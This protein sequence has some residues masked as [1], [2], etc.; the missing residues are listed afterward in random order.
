MLSDAMVIKSGDW[1]ARILPEI[2]ANPVK[3]TY[4]GEDVLRPLA[5]MDA[6]KI[7]PFLWGSP[8]LIPANRTDG[9][10]FT[11]EGKEY[12]L[13]LNEARLNNNLHGRMY[14]LDFKTERVDDTTLV[15]TYE[16]KGEAYPFPFTI[17]VTATVDDGGFSRK[18]E[19]TNT[20]SG[21]MPLTFA[22]HTTFV[23]N[24][25]V[26]VPLGRAHRRNERHIPLYYGDLNEMEQS[27]CNGV[28][29]RGLVI[30]GYFT[31]A[32]NVAHIGPYSLTVSENFDHWIM[33][34]NDGYQGYICVE[35]QAGRSN[36]LNDGGYIC[37]APGKTEVFTTRIALK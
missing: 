25:E 22:L 7:N 15:S 9:G 5:D 3:L 17:K 28:S 18:F 19:I 14:E 20:G 10:K 29:P 21:N 24:G 32:H 12:T 35:P 16:N 26:M 11:F 33:Y 4:K 13:P 6:L 27:I 30:S 8:I 2:G 1:E 31:S 34:N 23:E 36:G 37:L